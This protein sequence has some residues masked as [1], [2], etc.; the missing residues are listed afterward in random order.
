MTN[1]TPSADRQGTIGEEEELENWYFGDLCSRKKKDT[2][3]FMFQN[4]NGIGYTSKSVKCDS[5][6]KLIVN[7]NVDVMGLAETNIN[8]GKIRRPQTLPQTCKQWFKS[9]KVTTAY[10][11]KD[12]KRKTP[13]QPGGTAVISRGDMSLRHHAHECFMVTT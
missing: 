6:R 3:R 10:N 1:T 7:Y 12:K 8:W 13:H 4:I 2:I 9:S 5:V 11:L